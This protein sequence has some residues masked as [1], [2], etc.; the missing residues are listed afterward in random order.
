MSIINNIFMDRNRNRRFI[1]NFVCL[2]I[3]L[4]AIN[5]MLSE[6]GDF[7]SFST[8]KKAWAMVITML[9]SSFCGPLTASLMEL[10]LFIK[11]AF[12]NWDINSTFGLFVILTSAII[13]VFPVKKGWYRSWIKSLLT[14]PF[15]SILLDMAFSLVSLAYGIGDQIGKSLTYSI[16]ANF[17]FTPYA[18]AVVGICHVFFNYLPNRI[19]SL[20][21]GSQFFAES[22]VPRRKKLHPGVKDKVSMFIVA[23]ALILCNAAMVFA[24]ILFSK[25]A[26]RLTEGSPISQM[27][28]TDA[29]V[30]TNFAMLLSMLNFS[31][32]IILITRSFAVTHIATPISQM[33]TGMKNFTRNTIGGKTGGFEGDSYDISRLDIRTGDEIQDL[34][35]SLKSTTVQLSDYID[36]IQREQDL[37]EAVRVEKAANKA[38]TSFL[39]SMSHE[40]R[41][42]INAVLGLDEMILRESDE[43]HIIRYAADIKSAGRSLLSLI[44]DILDFSK[45]ESGKLELINAEYD[46]GSMI[47]DLMNMIS[48]RAEEKGLKLSV[49]VNPSTPRILYGDE[50]RIKQCILN[51]LTNAVKYTREGSVTMEIGWEEPSAE[52]MKCEGFAALGGDKSGNDRFVML[53]AKVTD[54]G[55]GI[56]A[57]DISKL[58]T[59]F[60]RIEEKRNRTIEGTGLGMNIVQ[61]L[62]AMMG[63]Y[64]EVK[65]EYGK[66][67]EFS[68]KVIQRVIAA[69]G[70]GDFAEIYRKNAEAASSYTASFIAPD[71]HILC[72]DDTAMNLTVFKGLLKETQVQIDTAS[73]G[74]E[75]LKLCR[76]KHYDILF[77]DHMMPTMDGIET[78]H[79]L[80][81]LE[82]NL[83][84]GV[85]AV[86]LTA[87]A[88][89]GAREMY[90]NE[91][92]TDYL[93]K[94]VNSIKLEKMIAS[95]LP[96][97]KVIRGAIAEKQ[98]PA[99]PLRLVDPV[100]QRL[101]QVAG[102]DIARS[103]EACGS[104]DVCKDVLRQ[105][106]ESGPDT[107]DTILHCMK[108]EEWK[109]YT[110]K[111]HALKSSSRLAG[112]DKL[113]ESAAQ[114]EQSGHIIQDNQPGSP[115][116]EEAL[117][118]IKSQTPVLMEEYKSLILALMEAL[119]NPALTA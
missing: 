113:S 48:S 92:F 20:F 111:V 87:N 21:I 53:R 96:P 83:C 68:F 37:K 70:V 94:P 11:M 25:S 4:T 104:P 75:A 60:Q 7:S 109:N 56:K 30:Q 58:F 82:P 26:D 62:L 2:A 114:L 27:F 10:I 35:E 3:A 76:E 51:I 43:D 61:N 31:V 49:I 39:S 55:I 102:I 24:F 17:S 13:A 77:I 81:H 44:N 105:Y 19:L 54:T 40:I 93:T 15:F 116:Y 9:L 101:S 59:A 91:G 100:L 12:I 6:I 45:I 67:S 41:T 66:G 42:P 110:V 33:A 99:E 74:V 47:N 80:E 95:Y 85:P 38:K 18:C 117:S 106:A 65:S 52:D 73:S 28:I 98:Q 16:T 57:E 69:E 8:G 32:P 22:K 36:S 90:I 118:Q 119:Q 1:V 23:E 108:K 14:V 89:S 5:L 115:H 79:A 97:E 29:L 112:L 78:L 34:Y 84:K 64:L 72:V 50:V 46:L 103:L 88:I 71:A 63:T 86:A 107:L